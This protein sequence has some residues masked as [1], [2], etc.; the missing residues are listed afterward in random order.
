MIQQLTCGFICCVT[1][2]W[3]DV[4]KW[5]RT[6][7]Q[8]KDIKSTLVSQLILLGLLSRM[9]VRGYRKQLY[10]QNPSNIATYKIKK[11]GAQY[12]AAG[13]TNWRESFLGSLGTLTLFK[14]IWLFFES[15]KHHGWSASSRQLDFSMSFK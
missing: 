2:F 12:T 14:A 11:S 3:G 8:S 6:T 4:N 7:D 15:S 5:E 1:D 13:S 9:W 10:H